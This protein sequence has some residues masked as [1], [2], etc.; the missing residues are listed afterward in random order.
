MWNLKNKTNE[1]TIQNRNRLID[2]ENNLVVTR[3]EGV[4][5]GMGKIQKE[6]KIQKYSYKINKTPGC[7]LQL[8]KNIVTTLYGDRW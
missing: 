7:N 8:V 3:G 6:I 4:G 1:Q 2:T 5:R